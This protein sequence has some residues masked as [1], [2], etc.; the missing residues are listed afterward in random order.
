[1]SKKSGKEKGDAK[2]INVEIAPGN[3]TRLDAYLE[4]YNARPDRKTPKLKYTDVLNASLDRFL[5]VRLVAL[6]TR[7]GRTPGK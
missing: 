7:L 5:N 3:R 6:R 4:R 2:K 1:V